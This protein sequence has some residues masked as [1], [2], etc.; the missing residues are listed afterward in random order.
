V[1]MEPKIVMWA[2]TQDGDGMCTCLGEYD[3]IED[4][5]IHT[6]CFGDNVEITF[7]YVTVSKSK[8]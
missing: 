3:S 1:D 2:T 5:V 6:A 8:E 4:V 7:E